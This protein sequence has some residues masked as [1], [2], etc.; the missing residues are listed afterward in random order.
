MKCKS[1]CV[2]LLLCF[3]L[4]LFTGCTEDEKKTEAVCVKC[5]G[6]AT[7]VLSGPADIMEKNGISLSACSQITSDVYAA[8]VCESCVGPVAEV[9]PDADILYNY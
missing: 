6:I 7:T 1:L 5:G 4:A 8:Y 9:K 3:F 2:A